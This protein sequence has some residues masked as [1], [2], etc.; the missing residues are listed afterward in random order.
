MWNAKE[1][2]KNSKLIKDVELG[3]IKKCNYCGMYSPIENFSSKYKYKNRIIF[4]ICNN[5]IDIL[6]K[7]EYIVVLEESS[8]ED[9]LEKYKKIK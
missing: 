4:D 6:N 8:Y 7:D 9:Y 5:C 2:S 1:I 3:N